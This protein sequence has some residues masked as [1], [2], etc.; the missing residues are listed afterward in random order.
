MAFTV[1]SLLPKVQPFR[2]DLEEERAIFAIQEA[3]RKVCRQTGY[4]QATHTVSS[5]ALTPTIDLS[6][7]FT[8]GDIHEIML[9]RLYDTKLSAYKALFPYNRTLID[10]MEAYRNYSTGWPTGWSFNGGN[11][12]EIY[13]TPDII[14]D[15]EVTAAV[16]PTGEIDTIPLPVEAEDAVVA[17][18][19][20]FLLMQPGPGQNLALSKDREIFHNREMDALRANALLGRSGRP[21]AQ[22]RPFATRAI[23]MYDN[24]WN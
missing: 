2:K 13:P 12:L 21:R 9:V 15:F 6:T 17:W 22:G 20:F 11:V 14:Y 24:R 3:V 18:A 4:A 7:A 5:I 19:Q 10:A 23:R 16:I 8:E 1:R